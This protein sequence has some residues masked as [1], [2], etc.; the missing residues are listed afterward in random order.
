MADTI[1]VANEYTA[2]HTDAAIQNI[3][4]SIKPVEYVGYCLTCR[5]D[6]PAPRRWCDAK[7]RD[8]YDRVKS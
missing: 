8:D 4:N 1:D 6:V 5:E 2:I 7:C 3:R